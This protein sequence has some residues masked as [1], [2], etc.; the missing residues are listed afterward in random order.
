MTTWHFS[1]QTPI[2][3]MFAISFTLENDIT[4]L[5]GIYSTSCKTNAIWLEGKVWCS[6]TTNEW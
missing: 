2:L 3:Y 1:Y 5:W 6:L 4:T